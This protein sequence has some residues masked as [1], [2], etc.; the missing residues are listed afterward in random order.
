MRIARQVSNCPPNQYIAILGS[1]GC[2]FA[3]ARKPCSGS[4][5][6]G[7][8]ST[9]RYVLR[10]S[11]AAVVPSRIVK[12]VELPGRMGKRPVERMAIEP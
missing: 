8:K 1:S 7:A 11:L 2:W 4:R 5:A 10:Q 6:C 3:D 12:P 9:G